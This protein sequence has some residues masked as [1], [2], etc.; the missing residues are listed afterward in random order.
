MKCDHCANPAT[1]QETKIQGGKVVQRNLCE[2]CAKALGVQTQAPEALAQALSQAVMA[3]AMSG[4]MQA[5]AGKSKAGSNT[6]P[7]CGITYGQFRQ[8]SMLGCPACY[9]AFEAQ[10]GPLLSRVHEGATH[11]VG[12][13]PRRAPAAVSEP[14]ARAQHP[15]SARSERAGR[16]DSQA[17]NPEAAAQELAKLRTQLTQAI[18]A[19]QY[20]RAAQLRDE[21]RRLSDESG[22]PSP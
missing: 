11:H 5:A 19:E 3:Q 16:G 12:K 6:C 2:Q 15:L 13:R 20:E 9:A 18:L 22:T 1:V 10:L 4:A 8:S 14:G 7:T 21:I 17:S